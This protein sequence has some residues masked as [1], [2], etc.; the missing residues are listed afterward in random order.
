MLE[1]SNGIHDTFDGNPVVIPSEDLNEWPAQ[2]QLTNASM[3]Y[4]SQDLH[5]F[6]VDRPYQSVDISL[7]DYDGVCRTYRRLG[8]QWY[9][10]LYRRVQDWSVDYQQGALLKDDWQQYHYRFNALWQRIMLRGHVDVHGRA[11]ICDLT[12]YPLPVPIPEQFF[13]ILPL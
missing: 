8:V 10:W 6:T 2:E 13:D 3:V 1:H 9:A 7:I 11:I 12:D 5:G 4:V